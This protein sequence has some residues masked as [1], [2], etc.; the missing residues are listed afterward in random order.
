MYIST[1]CKLNLKSWNVI[2]ERK[3]GCT[4]VIFVCVCCGGGGVGRTKTV[5][6][7]GQKERFTQF[8]NISKYINETSYGDS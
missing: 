6:V 1:C 5:A 2:W 8:T 7:G 3:V 4:C